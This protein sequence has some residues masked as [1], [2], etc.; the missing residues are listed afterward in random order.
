MRSDEITVPKPEKWPEKTGSKVS[1][2]AYFKALSGKDR[3]RAQPKASPE[4]SG[5][6]KELEKTRLDTCD[7]A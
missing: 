4:R 6:M 2:F 5:L 1:L 7:N 3:H